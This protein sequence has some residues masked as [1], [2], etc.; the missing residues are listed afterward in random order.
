MT[1]VLKKNKKTVEAAFR[2]YSNKRITMRS[3]DEQLVDQFT[4]Q[5]IHFLTTAG[6]GLGGIRSVFKAI[7]D[8]KRIP[9]KD[10]DIDYAG[11]ATYIREVGEAEIQTMGMK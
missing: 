5:K 9:Y 4:I 1:E 10:W 6:G 11:I 2:E 8:K 3:W 7:L